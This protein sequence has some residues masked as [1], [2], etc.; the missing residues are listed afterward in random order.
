MVSE[1]SDERLNALF[2]TYR[3]RYWPGRLRGYRVSA[4]AIDSAHGECDTASKSIWI[5]ISRHTSDYEVRSTLLHEMAHAA[6]GRRSR[7]HD[8]RF[9][10]ELEHLLRSGARLS[11]DLAENENRPDISSV[12]DRFPLSKKALTPAYARRR[13][14]IVGS[15]DGQRDIGDEVITAFENLGANGVTWTRT[16]LYAGHEFGL[17]DVDDCVLASEQAKI[18]TL[19]R[20]HRHGVNLRA[21][22]AASGARK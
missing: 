13:R 15:R 5:D 14:S 20:A 22:F 8:S 21:S 12:P 7:G 11:I 1:W 4:I 2:L 18:P 10:T 17:L 3:D 9:F 19:R 6:A 16:L